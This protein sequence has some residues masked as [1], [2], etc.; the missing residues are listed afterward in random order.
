MEQLNIIRNN[1][2]EQ[3]KIIDA[4][5]ERFNN[6]N[7]K[8][9]SMHFTYACGF[10]IGFKCGYKKPL[11]TGN[12]N[13]PINHSPMADEVLEILVGQK[14]NN[15]V[16]LPDMAWYGLTE[17]I[18]RSISRHSSVVDDYILLDRCGIMSTNA[19]LYIDDIHNKNIKAIYEN[20]DCALQL[21]KVFELDPEDYR[22]DLNAIEIIKNA[23]VDVTPFS[24][25]FE[26]I[27]DDLNTKL[28]ETSDNVF[29]DLIQK[30]LLNESNE[31]IKTE[32]A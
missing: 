26:R 12:I 14:D 10:T 16:S 32:T 7:W 25:F 18:C 11:F 9:T 30:N 20:F 19:R 5:I 24:M 23:K 17:I 13:L 28:N 3:L 4:E 2:L 27:V 15:I 8:E 29:I 22:G 21:M 6:E 31:T 1:C